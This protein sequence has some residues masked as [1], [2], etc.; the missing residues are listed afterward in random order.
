MLILRDLLFK[1]CRHYADFLGSEEGIST[2]ILAARLAG[3]EAEGMLIKQV[4]PEHGA[5]FIYRP[6]EKCLELIPAMLEIIE[7]SEKWDA[8]TG[9][10]KSFISELRDDR[11]ALAAK[12]KVQFQ[13]LNS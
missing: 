13:P 10:P 5:R 3:L 1:G 8:N 4:D 6:S 9:V 7:W 12:L 2:N 11:V